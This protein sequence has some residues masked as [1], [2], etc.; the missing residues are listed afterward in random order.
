MLLLRPTSN[1]NNHKQKSNTSALKSGDVVHFHIFISLLKPAAITQVICMHR[2][3]EE[4][5]NISAPHG[6]NEPAVN[7]D[8]HKSSKTLQKT[9]RKWHHNISSPGK[10]LTFNS[11][12]RILKNCSSTF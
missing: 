9:V 8:S 5:R 7:H 11:T 3:T 1:L 2:E 10:S 6:D 12:D 4:D